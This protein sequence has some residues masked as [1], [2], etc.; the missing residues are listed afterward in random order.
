[1]MLQKRRK[2]IIFMIYIATAGTAFFI[3]QTNLEHYR[4]FMGNL[5]AVTLGFFVGNMAE[6]AK[7]FI[8]TR[9][10]N[11]SEVTQASD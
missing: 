2:I 4:I 10:I 7:D 5:T 11:K 9:R 1:M 3:M 6:H 8:Q